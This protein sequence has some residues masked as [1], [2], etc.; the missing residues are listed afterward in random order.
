[1]KLDEAKALLEALIFSAA[2]PVSSDQLAEISEIDKHTVEALLEQLVRE[3]EASGHGIALLRVGG[4]YIFGTKPQYASHIQRLHEPVIRTGLSQAALETLAVIAYKQPC[5]KL[6]IERIRGVKVDSSINSLLERGLIQEVG[7]KNAPGRP[8][9]YA[10]TEE[11]LIR[12]G[13]NSLDDLPAL[14]EKSLFQLQE[15]VSA[16]EE[17]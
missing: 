15:I 17:N 7:R 10:T 9:L 2:D 13:L 3:Y 12:F 16:S 4:G 14:P 5:T 6:E 8:I 1:M 11:F